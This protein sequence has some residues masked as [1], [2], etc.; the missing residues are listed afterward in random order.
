M[1]SL[2]PILSWFGI[3]WLFFLVHT[4]VVHP[5]L[6]G[7]SFFLSIS[8][9][10]IQFVSFTSTFAFVLVMFLFMF[11]FYGSVLPCLI[12]GVTLIHRDYNNLLFSH[13]CRFLVC[14]DLLS[15]LVNVQNISNLKIFT[16]TCYY[17]KWGLTTS[18]PSKVQG[19][20]SGI[21]ISRW[22]G[23]SPTSQLQTVSSQSVFT[24]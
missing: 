10:S 5:T 7:F 9:F 11:F 16:C 12:S 6:S 3:R 17:S 19:S 4:R 21:Q 15:I 23:G 24:G 8:C 13:L 22:L 14:Q 2:L 1:I 20:G 18:R